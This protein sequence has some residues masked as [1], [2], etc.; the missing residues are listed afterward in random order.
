MWTFDS[1]EFQKRIGL[2]LLV[3]SQCFFVDYYVV[4]CFQD[5]LLSTLRA[6]LTPALSAPSEDFPNNVLSGAVYG[7]AMV[8]NPFL[9]FGKNWWRFGSELIFITSFICWQLHH[10]G[11]RFS[12]IIAPVTYLWRPYHNIDGCDDPMRIDGSSSTRQV[13]VWIHAAAFRE[14]YEALKSAC[15]MQVSFKFFKFQSLFS[16]VIISFWTVW[17]KIYVYSLLVVLIFQMAEDGTLI[18]CVSLEGE[19]AKLEVMGSKVSE[20]LKKIIH[21]VTRWDIKYY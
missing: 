19:L 1:H 2:F 12:H 3:W 8:G 7:K 10:V 20:L 21:P 11:V 16:N 15:Q 6:V 4:I 5:L 9:P 17:D 13:W 18:N 14:G